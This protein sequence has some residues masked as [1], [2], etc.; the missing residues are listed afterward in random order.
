LLHDDLVI[1]AAMTAILDE[2]DWT[3]SFS[4]TLIQ[5][6]DPLKEMDGGF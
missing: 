3:P 5:A 4:P 2:L 1:S 6:S